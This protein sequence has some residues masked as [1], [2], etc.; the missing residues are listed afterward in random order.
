MNNKG[1]MIIIALILVG[2][3]G[4]LVVQ[5]QEDQKSPIEQI[6]DGVNEG[7]EEIG[8]EIDDATTTRN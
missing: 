6:S 3:F 2:I 8:D 7:V 1:L 4:V 5:Y